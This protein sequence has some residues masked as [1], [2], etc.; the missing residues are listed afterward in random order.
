MDNLGSVSLRRNSPNCTE[1]RRAVTRADSI[2][3]N[4]IGVSEDRWGF[5]F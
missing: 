2:K 3:A 5:W 1:S 4:E